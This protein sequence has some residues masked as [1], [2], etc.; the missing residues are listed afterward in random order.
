MQDAHHAPRSQSEHTYKGAWGAIVFCHERCL[1]PLACT[2]V[3]CLYHPQGVWGDCSSQAVPTQPP[4]T[5]SLAS[6]AATILNGVGLSLLSLLGKLGLKS[7][8][9]I[10]QSPE[11]KRRKK[12]QQRKQY[13]MRIM[14]II[15]IYNVLLK[16]SY[17]C[18]AAPHS[19]SW[20]MLLP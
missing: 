2:P 5:S 19:A 10:K 11:R 6:A 4:L 16:A 20:L 17:S 14:S 18:H 3:F 1:S 15:T 12:P 9:S 8:G 13:S 7:K